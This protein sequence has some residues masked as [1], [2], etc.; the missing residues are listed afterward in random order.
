VWLLTPLGFFSIVRK[1]DDVGWGTL[2]VRARVKSDLEALREHCLPDLGEI[3]ENA[4]T[5]YRYRAK[6]KRSQV[7]EALAK[8]VQDLDYENF[9]NEVAK[10]QGKH[11]AAAYG[12]VWDVLCKLQTGSE[13]HP[14]LKSDD[15]A[16]RE[17]P[18]AFGGIVVDANGRILLRRPKGDFDGYV[19]T[20]PKGRPEAGETPEQAALREVKEETGYSARVVGKVAG[21]FRGGTSVTE[22]FLMSPVGSPARFSAETSAIQWATFDKAAK[23]IGMT[24]NKIGQDRDLSVLGAARLALKV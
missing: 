19:W 14:S 18:R 7:A 4:G 3:E 16:P 17:K 12:K 6:A 24:K 1:P 2:T 13:Q 8:L 20:F 5:D 21:S 9:K 22:Y 10:K 11:R 15:L 23:L